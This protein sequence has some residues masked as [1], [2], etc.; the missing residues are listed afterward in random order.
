LHSTLSN[1]Y[2]RTY[3]EILGL[4][5]DCTQKEIRNAFVNLSKEHHPD[6]KTNKSASKE[7]NQE[8]IKVMEAYQV[9]SKAHRLV[10][11]G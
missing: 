8:F 2:R 11:L 3:Y 6:V 1:L 4:K 5:D 10:F 9:L 7:E